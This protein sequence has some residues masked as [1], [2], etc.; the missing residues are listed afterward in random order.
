MTR[1][2]EIEQAVA[3]LPDDDYRT[4]RQWFLS[5]DW[6][7]W[8]LQIEDDSKGGKLAFLLDEANQSKQN[9]ALREF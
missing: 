1:I 5:R 6:E 4:F 3:A 7:K 9:G 2:E 8:D